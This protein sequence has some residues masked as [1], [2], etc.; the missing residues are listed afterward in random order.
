M[1]GSAARTLL[2]AIVVATRV[3][4]VAIAA[5]GSTTT[6]SGVSRRPSD[7][8][9]DTLFTLGMLLLIP[10][11]AL[12][13]YGLL[14][15]RAIAE[16]MASG[17]YRRLS[18]VGFFATVLLL[19]GAAYLFRRNWQPVE[20]EDDAI[21]I[22][23]APIGNPQET[24]PVSPG[25]LYEPQLALVPALVVVAIVVIGL[26]A[27]YL[28]MRRRAGAAD[29]ERT[30]S[31][32]LADMLADTLDDLRSE[33]DPRRAVIAAYARFERVLEANG[34]PRRAAE[35][36]EEY[37]ARIL[38]DL[39]V[40][41]RSVR[42]LTSLFEEAKFS[43]HEVGTAMKEEAIDTLEAVRDELRV[44]SGSRSPVLAGPEPAVQA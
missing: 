1:R 30:V 38:G 26:A 27:A 24:T 11:A 4:V 15:R 12:L 36:P 3:A 7:T 33:R 37:L 20:A 9:L 17:R 13:L 35:T 39:D 19:S 22:P 2:P 10:A 28:A 23:N 29:L 41:E 42:R 43:D 5:T 44:A 32:T 25:E 14:Q 40:S 31:R 6:G 16:E 8:V 18:W 34:L 21:A